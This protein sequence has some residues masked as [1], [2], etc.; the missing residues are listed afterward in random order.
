VGVARMLHLPRRSVAGKKE[1]AG[2]VLK[3]VK[4]VVTQPLYRKGQCLALGVIKGISI[5]DSFLF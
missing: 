1:S 4:A 2:I 5:M 3:E